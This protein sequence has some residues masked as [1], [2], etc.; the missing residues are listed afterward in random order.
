[1]STFYGVKCNDV[2]EVIIENFRDVLTSLNGTS[3]PP[4]YVLRLFEKENSYHYDHP[5]NLVSKKYFR[6]VLFFN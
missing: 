4:S 2:G 6:L 5:F 1:M 3:V